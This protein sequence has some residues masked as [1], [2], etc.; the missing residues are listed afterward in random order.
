MFLVPEIAPVASRTT[1]LSSSY[2][3]LKFEAYV[4]VPG[5]ETRVFQLMSVPLS[6]AASHQLVEAVTFTAA[7]SYTVALS[8]ASAAVVPNCPRS[9]ES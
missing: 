7:S 8:R 1:I 3:E 5:L 6:F 9:T 4:D 2:L